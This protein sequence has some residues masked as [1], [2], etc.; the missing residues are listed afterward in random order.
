MRFFVLGGAGIIGRVVVRD[1]FQYAKDADIV[2]AERDVKKARAFAITFKSKR[3]Q[4][5][6]ADAS[7]PENLT[8]LFRSARVVASCVRHEFNPGV[9]ASCLKAGSNYVDL[10]GMFH[11]TK[12]EQRFHTA[13]KKLGI[14]GVLGMGGAPGLSNV[15]AVAGSEGLQTLES[16]DIVFADVDNT[17]YQ[18][19]FV[20]PYSFK[21]LVDEYTMKPAVFEH[22]KLLFVQPESGKKAYDFG[23]DF[24]KQTG[25]LTLHSEL[26]TLPA[27]FK[28]RGLRTCEFHVTF[29]AAFSET[30]ETLIALGFASHERVRVGKAEAEILEVTARLMDSWIPKPGTKINDKELVRVII[31]G[32]GKTIIMDAVTKSDGLYPAGVLDTGIPCAIVCQMLADKTIQKRGVFAPESVVPLTQFFAALKQRGI[33]ILKNGKEV[34]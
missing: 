6:Q 31:R 30:I 32:A 24:G 33:T 2:V 13:Y 20:L 12:R 19:P 23:L 17:K 34:N 4:A 29:P 3:V 15:L 26:A 22:G 7:K 25:F 11:Y 27:F 21:T 10:G 16:I 1:L 8:R 5:V 14:T 9:M 18:Q 28:N